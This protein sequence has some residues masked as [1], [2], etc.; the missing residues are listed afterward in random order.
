MMVKVLGT[1]LYLAHAVI[2]VEYLMELHC[3]HVPI[4]SIVLAA[5]TFVPHPSFTTRQR[6]TIKM[7]HMTSSSHIYDSALRAA[8]HP[9]LYH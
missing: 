9:A 8:L 1:K 5:L 6:R 2:S 4:C 3:A 7:L